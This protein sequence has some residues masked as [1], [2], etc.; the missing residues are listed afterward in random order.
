M[1]ATGPWQIERDNTTELKPLWA[2]KAAQR[3]GDE[4]DRVVARRD[5]PGS[6]RV[7]TRGARNRR[8]RREDE[9]RILDRGERAER[10]GGNDGL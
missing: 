10:A 4:A 7:L 9:G 1:P 8:G 5:S 6:D 3:P 2:R